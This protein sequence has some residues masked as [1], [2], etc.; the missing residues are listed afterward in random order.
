[1]LISACASTP[2]TNQLVRHPPADIDSSRELHEVPFFPQRDYQCGPAALA[3]LLSHRDI[4]V[5]ADDLT[6]RVYIPARKGSLQIEMIATARSYNFVIYKLEPDLYTLLKEVNQGNPVLVFQ[7]LSFRFWP[8]WHYAVVVGYDLDKR[9]LLLR[10][11]TIEKYTISF[12]TFERTWQRAN[13]WAYILV[14]PGEVPLT[15]SPLA[16]TKASH[17]LESSGFKKS[18]LKALR[19]GASRWP[20]ESILLM[21]LGNAEYAARNYDKANQSFSRELQLRPDNAAAWNNLA[22]TLAARSCKSAALKA[23]AC[24]LELT[25]EDQNL[26]SS[27]LELRAMEVKSQGKGSCKVRQCRGGG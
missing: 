8:Q 12:S 4:K 18:T 23:I 3:T 17:S 22:Y 6:D 5:H 24:A 21:A 19:A 26:Q 15:A 2:Q 20:E 14:K 10:S 11:G 1:M 9:E 13:H 7:N 25:P 16:Y 27:A